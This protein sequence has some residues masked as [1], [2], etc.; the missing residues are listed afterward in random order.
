MTGA[1]ALS[2]AASS[3]TA[4]APSLSASAA[5]D[6]SNYAKLLQ[7]SLYLYDAN[8][9]GSCDGCGME[10]RSSCHMSDAVKGGFHDAGDHVMFGLPQGYAASTLGWSYYEYKDVFDYLGQTGHLKLITDHFCKYFKD[11]TTISSGV[12]GGAAVTD[13]VYQIGDGNADHNSYWGPPEQQDSSSRKVFK[14]SSGASDVAAEYAAALAVNYINFGNAED[15]TYAEALFDFSTKFNQVA[16]EGVCYP[17]AEFC[18]GGEFLL[19]LD[20]E[21]ASE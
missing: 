19:V 21:L 18:F 15:L 12:A 9:C 14:T 5:D 16:S 6:G 10:W 2:T 11:C 17:E 1:L 8:M 20:T 3:F 13:F 4:A 7:Y